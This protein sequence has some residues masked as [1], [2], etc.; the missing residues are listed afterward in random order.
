MYNSFT[1]P[2]TGSFT[3]QQSNITVPY[4]QPR[5]QSEFRSQ[6]NEFSSRVPTIAT[7]RSPPGFPANFRRPDN[8][9]TRSQSQ[10]NASINITFNSGARGNIINRDVSQM[11]N[12]P[13][14]S[15]SYSQSQVNS[16]QMNDSR[17]REIT[18]SFTRPVDPL[19]IQFNSQI[20]GQQFP[21]KLNFQLTFTNQHI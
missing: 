2:V 10:D 19:N 5:N 8:Y 18:Q 13:P 16:L 1:N 20:A 11:I 7:I 3:S 9:S 12:Y 21:P 4:Q 14:T 17:N 6:T 15:V